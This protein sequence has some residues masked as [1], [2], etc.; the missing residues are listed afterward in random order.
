MPLFKVF[1]FLLIGIT[2]QPIEIISQNL[3]EIK[4]SGYVVE[5]KSKLAVE[6]CKIALLFSNGINIETQTDSLGFFCFDISKDK[7][8]Q[9]IIVCEKNMFYT[10]KLRVDLRNVSSDTLINIDMTLVKLLTSW[11]PDFYFEYNSLNS[12]S[13][14]DT[15]LSFYLNF[16]Q[17]NDNIS[18]DIIGFKDSSETIDLRYERAALIYN[19]FIELGANRNRFT[20]KISESPNI[21]KPEYEELDFATGEPVKIFLTEQFISNQASEKID[22]LRRLNRSVTLVINKL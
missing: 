10:E 13:D 9:L 3:E 17:Q 22:S 1:A 7:D 2:L 21:L 15:T 12:E 14:F 19:M 8:M 20:I 18:F 11:L 5:K 4:I 6:N 16:L